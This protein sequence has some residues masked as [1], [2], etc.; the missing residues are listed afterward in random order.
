MHPSRLALGCIV[1]TGFCLF[2]V[3][4]LLSS[5]IYLSSWGQVYEGWVGKPVASFT[6]VNGNPDAIQQL[7]NGNAE[8]IW[9]FQRIDPECRQHFEVNSSGTI[10]GSRHTGRC[11]PVG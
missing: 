10:V 6:E 7:E 2:V 3:S 4:P 1:R 5:C 8:H 9:Y 11:V